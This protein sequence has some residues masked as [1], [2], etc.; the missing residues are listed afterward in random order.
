MEATTLCVSGSSGSSKVSFRTYH[1][2]S[3]LWTCW[4]PQ[5]LRQVWKYGLIYLHQ[6]D[7]SFETA[8]TLCREAG[9]QMTLTA[10]NRGHTIFLS[11][12]TSPKMCGIYVLPSIQT[13]WNLIQYVGALLLSTIDHGAERKSMASLKLPLLQQVAWGSPDWGKANLHKQAWWISFDCCQLRS[14]KSNSPTASKQPHN[15]YNLYESQSTHDIRKGKFP[16][17]CKP[18]LFPK[19]NPSLL[20][21]FIMST[22][23]SSSA[24]DFNESPPRTSAYLKCLAENTGFP[25]HPQTVLLHGHWPSFTRESAIETEIVLGGFKYS[26]SSITAGNGAAHIVKQLSRISPLK[27]WSAI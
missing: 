24:S 8:S 14:C 17:L 11:S 9:T 10:C 2:T 6:H 19:N 22:D 15:T 4:V 18:R 12:N 27:Q 5:I 25:F 7:N 16:D 3:I 23:S 13:L 1:K 26:Q 21:L 20:A